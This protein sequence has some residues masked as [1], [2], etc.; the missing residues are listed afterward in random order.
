M[1]TLSALTLI[2]H[3]QN[4]TQP[5][6]SV[7]DF[8]DHASVSSTLPQT[9]GRGLTIASGS[10]S[11]AGKV[12]TIK[13]Y[14]TIQPDHSTRFALNVG[15][16]AIR[17]FNGAIISSGTA[18]GSFECELSATASSTVRAVCRSWIGNAGSLDVT[19]NAVAVSGPVSVNIGV[20]TDGTLGAVIQHSLQVGF[21]N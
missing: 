7:G 16:V 3:A 8:A 14:V 12:T 6:C 17:V 10:L 5:H 21:D 19:D 15:G 13:G 9:L 11:T 2:V 18:T 4:C 1:M 20:T